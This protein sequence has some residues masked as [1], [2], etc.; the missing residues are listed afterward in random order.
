MQNLRSSNNADLMQFMGM[1]LYLFGKDSFFGP[2]TPLQQIALVEDS[3]AYMIGTSNPLFLQAKEKYCDLIVNLDL[4]TIEI[5]DTKHRAALALSGA[6]RKWISMLTD[7]VDKSWDPGN[8]DM[9]NSR[10]F[11]GSEE[12]IRRQFQDYIYGLCSFKTF[13]RF[14]ESQPQQHRLEIGL[15]H[16]E[17]MINF[18]P[19]F[20]RD[21]TKTTHFDIWLDLCDEEIF[22]V[23]EPRHPCMEHP[24]S[25]ADMQLRL[26]SA[27]GN[28]KLEERTASTRAAIGRTWTQGADRFNRFMADTLTR[29][30][31]DIQ[32]RITNPGE[33]VHEKDSEIQVTPSQPYLATARERFSRNWLQLARHAQEG[34]RELSSRVSSLMAAQQSET[35]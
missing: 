19:F 12:Y 30:S 11:E 29:P 31:S 32:Q 3:K 10:A 16:D 1:P 23:I 26:A 20:L 22:N 21:W 9:P 28:L 14:L 33:P 7:L 15:D 6:D 25:V 35:K 4:Q 18:N 17:Q 8:P 24:I 34:K 5:V 13:D 27:V 2:Y